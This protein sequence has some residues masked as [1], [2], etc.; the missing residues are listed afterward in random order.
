MAETIEQIYTRMLSNVSDTYD[1]TEGQFITDASKTVAIELSKSSSERDQ[2]SIKLFP[3]TSYDEWLDLWVESHGMKRKLGEKAISQTP[4]VF[5]CETGKLI[6]KETVV[7]SDSGLRYLTTDDVVGVNGSA[8]TNVIAEDVGT[9]YNT[10]ANTIKTLAFTIDGV[11]TVNNPSPTVGGADKET[12]DE[13]RDR[14]FEQL[15]NPNLGGADRDYIRWA[16]EVEGVEDAKCIPEYLGFGTNSVKLVVYGE[17]GDSLD[18]TI[19]QDVIDHIVSPNDRSKRL[20]PS[21]AVSILIVTST[22]V[23]ID[24]GIQGLTIKAGYTLENVQSL[25]QSNLRS[26]IAAVKPSETVKIKALESVIT[27]TEGVNDFTSITI[28]GGTVNIPT[29]DEQ[30]AK[31]GVISYV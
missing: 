8:I 1:K 5:T 28:N 21:S 25:I 18:S 23:L 10:P 24:I 17:N 26:H 19:V 31:L 27:E 2:I 30:K 9:Q 22:N 12:N 11:Y 7:L 3:Q 20:A 14:Y 6:P 29:N 13:L 16:K 4:V 15:A